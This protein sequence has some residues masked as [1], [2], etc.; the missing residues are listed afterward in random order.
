MKAKDLI[1][2]ITNAEKV[3]LEKKKNATDQR[4]MAKPLKQSVIKPKGKGKGKSL[5]KSRKGPRTQ[6]FCH[7]CGIQGHT[8]P[9]FHK[10]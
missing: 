1:V 9:N 8:R 3:K 2:A 7:H 10:L 4:F 5:P 6:H